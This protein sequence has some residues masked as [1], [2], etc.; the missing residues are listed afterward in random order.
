[1]KGNMVIALG[2]LASLFVMVLSISIHRNSIITVTSL[3]MLATIGQYALLGRW[4]TVALSVVTLLYGLVTLLERRY[5]WLKSKWALVTLF[6]SYTGVFMVMNG[7]T[8]S[9]DV[10]AF[11]ASLS[12]VVLMTLANPLAA[13][14]V[15]LFNGLTWSA[16]QIATGAYGQLP[17]EAVFIFG[18]V[19]SMVMLYRARAQGQPLSSVPELAQVMRDKFP[20]K[21]TR[22]DRAMDIPSP[23][24]ESAT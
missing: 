5:P 9:V 2:L 8:F 20:K 10:I 1:M 17:G 12:G 3:L 13:K 22:A 11:L 6:A 7:L 14:W 23:M 15:M 19:A 21:M 24:V 16:Y 18:V 4:P